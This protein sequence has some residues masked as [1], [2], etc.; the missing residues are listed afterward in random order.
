MTKEDIQALVDQMACASCFDDRQIFYAILER[1]HSGVPVTV[2]LDMGDAVVGGTEGSVLF[3]GPGGTLA[4]DNTNFFYSDAAN[5]LRVGGSIVTPLVVGGAGV[6]DA[7]TLKGTSG[8]GTLTAAALKVLVGNNG[9]TEALR[10]LNDGTMAIGTLNPVSAALTIVATGATTFAAIRYSD[11]AG[12]MPT[13]AI[14]RAG[15]IDGAPSGVLSGWLLGGAAF[16]GMDSGGSYR[17]AA[18]IKAEARE[19]F[20]STACGG[21]LVFETV[22]VGTTTLLE[23]LFL[24]EGGFLGLATSAPDGKLEVNL[25]PGE[26][27]RFTYNDANGSATTYM[28]TTVSSV[29]LTTF[30]AAGSAPGFLFPQTVTHTGSMIVKSVTDAGP[31]TATNGTVAEIVFNTSDSKFYGCVATG[32]PATWAALN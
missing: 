1:L 14:Q 13:F 15:G 9:A 5:Q 7:L 8:N 12:S 6:T 20:T 16:R 29:G 27:I 24:T 25:L 2:Q 3:I 11:T 22:A 21:R 17:N 30:T 18:R 19:N 4:Q 26:K 32:A 10:V 28:D 31:M 23:R